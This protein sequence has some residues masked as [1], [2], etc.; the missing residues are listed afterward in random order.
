MD[1]WRY[2][3]NV[4][5][6]FSHA[7]VRIAGAAGTT[8]R[9][10]SASQ[11]LLV[12]LGSG[13]P[14]VRISN[15]RLLGRLRVEDGELSLVDCR[16]EEDAPDRRRQLSATEGSARALSISGGQA[17][18]TRTTLQGLTAGAI[19]VENANV[20]LDQCSIQDCQAQSGGAVLVGEG[21][22]LRVDGSIFTGNIA[23]ISGGALQV[24]VALSI[25]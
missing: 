11:P 22:V 10:A 1:S 8:L 6:T 25:S 3:H 2:A 23:V 21:A 9:P 13:A 19:S 17:Y 24:G 15:V 16:V 18:L 12:T 7:Q 20:I 14:P 4:L 5:T